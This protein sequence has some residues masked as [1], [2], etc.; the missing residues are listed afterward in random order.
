MTSHNA[1]VQ[2]RMLG[3]AVLKGTGVMF[4]SEDR[5]GLHTAWCHRYRVGWGVTAQHD[6]NQPGLTWQHICVCVCVALRQDSEVMGFSQPLEGGDLK[7]LGRRREEE[8][9]EESPT[10]S[11]SALSRGGWSHRGKE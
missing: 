8:G 6:S 9:L 4:M 2:R 11:L 10:E 5:V 3:A 1:G 7:C